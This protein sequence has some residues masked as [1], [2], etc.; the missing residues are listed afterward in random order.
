MTDVI[1]ADLTG[2]ELHAIGY[3]QSAEPSSPIAGVVW[4]D[5]TSGT[6]LYII[7][8]RNAA[9]SAWEIL[10]NFASPHTAIGSTTPVA[11]TFTSLVVNG[12]AGTARQLLFKSTAVTR[13]AMEVNNVAEGGANAGSNLIFAAYTDAGALTGTALELN[14][15]NRTVKT[16]AELNVVGDLNHDGT[17][18]GVFGVTPA[19]RGALAVPTGSIQRTTYATS[20]VTLAQLAGVVMAMITDFRSMGF[21]S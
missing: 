15:A 8:V 20:T 14:R 18:I 5:T 17:N 2:S 6:G 4:V 11:G 10:T 19:P 16:F 21:F 13:W 9:N 3:I 7:K 1:H 12:A